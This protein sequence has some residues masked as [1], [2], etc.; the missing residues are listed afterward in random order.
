[1][2][3]IMRNYVGKQGT[4]EESEG[5][6]QMNLR[7]FSFALLVKPDLSQYGIGPGLDICH[8]C[9]KIIGTDT[10]DRHGPRY[11]QGMIPHP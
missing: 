8:V 4:P 6:K 7:D 10:L 1:M 9:F 5:Y 3:N 2:A 11:S